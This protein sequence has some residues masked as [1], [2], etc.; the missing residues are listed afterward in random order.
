MNITAAARL[1]KAGP[2]LCFKSLNMVNPKL[3]GSSC[4]QSSTYSS[5]EAIY[6]LPIIA[7]I[8]QV[9]ESQNNLG[10]KPSGFGPQPKSLTAKNS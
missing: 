2:C 10:H 1:L 9:I 6:K 7:K 5:S 3:N 8:A 4:L